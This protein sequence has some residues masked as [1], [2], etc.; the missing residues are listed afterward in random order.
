MRSHKIVPAALAAFAAGG[1][2]AAPSTAAAAS[3]DTPTPNIVGGHNAT[4]ARGAVSLQFDAPKN[5]VVDHH[6]CTGALFMREWVLTAAHCVKDMPSTAF[7]AAGAAPLGFWGSTLSASIPTADKTFHVRAGSLDRT[8]GG[9]TSVVDALFP[10]PGF[11]WA[12]GAPTVEVDDLALLHLATPLD[13]PTVPLAAPGPEIGRNV[14]LLG[15]GGDTPNPAP[16][17]LPRYLKQLTTRIVVPAKCVEAAQSAK[18]NCTDNPNGTD[19]PGPG[20]SGGPEIAKDRNNQ[21]VL[22]GLCSRG[23]SPF[24]GAGKTT[25]T[26][27]AKFRT[28][29]FDTITKFYTGGGAT[30]H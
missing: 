8:Q 23:T 10:H 11:N 28:W 4:D 18:E 1:L 15:W 17:S 21:D 7:R 5:G 29:I 16:T 27:V 9:V 2:L 14:A 3:I 13:V 22:V 25:Y 24:P 26:S 12:I 6:T 30:T 19:G 20:D